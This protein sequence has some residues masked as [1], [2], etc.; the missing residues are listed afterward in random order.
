[1]KF[2]VRWNPLVVTFEVIPDDRIVRV[3]TVQRLPRRHGQP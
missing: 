1:M 2:Q 3:L